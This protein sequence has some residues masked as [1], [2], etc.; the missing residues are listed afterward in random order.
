MFELIIGLILF[1]IGGWW[2]YSYKKFFKNA[3]IV[4][5]IISG[6]KTYQKHEKEREITM[7]DAV[8]SFSFEG[9][10]REITGKISSSTKPKVGTYCKIGIN[11]TNVQDIRV[12]TMGEKIF[13]YG[14]I[15][16]GLFWIITG[17]VRLF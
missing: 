3:I 9:K 14:F 17:L 11:P 5:G 10:P 16:F 8:I 4:Q 12:E 6:Y 1:G 2:W 15:G 7:Y 13:F